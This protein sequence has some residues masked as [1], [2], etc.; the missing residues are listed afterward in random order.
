MC[1]LW[2]WCCARCACDGV[3][4]VA[5]IS[6][7]GLCHQHRSSE[8]CDAQTH[9]G[10][11]QGSHF[12]PQGKAQGSAR[13]GAAMR[14]RRRVGGR[15]QRSREQLC[16]TLSPGRGAEEQR[17]AAQQA[18][19]E[20]GHHPRHRLQLPG[21]TGQI[22]APQFPPVPPGEE[23]DAA[24]G[25][26]RAVGQEAV[27]SPAHAARPRPGCRCLTLVLAGEDVER[28]V[29]KGWVPAEVMGPRCRVSSLRGSGPD[30]VPEP[31]VTVVAPQGCGTIHLPGD[32][33]GREGHSL[34]L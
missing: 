25:L 31:Q 12:P 29:K 34:L 17:G 8:L 23:G 28:G 15:S 22:S 24:G 20:G 18:E 2:L 27:G 6:P 4:A 9:L 14:K 16:L 10:P 3:P 33:M 11:A 26:S 5:L 13:R 21:G 7:E 30:S 19:G 32:G 1:Q